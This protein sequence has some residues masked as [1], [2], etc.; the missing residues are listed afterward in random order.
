MNEYQKTNDV[1]RKYRAIS[2]VDLEKFRVVVGESDL[3][4]MS[5]T[6]TINVKDFITR[7]LKYYRRILKEFIANYPLFEKSLKP[8][9]DHPD[10]PDIIR[11]MIRS[12]A[13]AGTGPM[14]S[15]A[16]AIAGI[17]GEEVDKDVTE[18]IIENGG[19][20]YLRTSH[21]R[22]VSIFAGNSPLSNCIGLVIQPT[23]RLGICTSAGTVGPSLSFG[24]A[25]AAVII[26]P[27]PAL[28]DAVATATANLIKSS[29]DFPKAIS[30]VKR[31]P[32][33]DGVLIIKDDKMAVWGNIEI[34][35]I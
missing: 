34:T 21:K 33:I 30:F 35:P 18:L 1:E 27:D 5:S 23:D 20:I 10:A 19:D 16:G 7:R 9:P 32:N 17:I 8:F 29:Q 11:W 12:S 26:S 14:A 6:S 2:A 28:A 24:K 31:I 22:I 15:V 25:D 13:L 3:W 4:V